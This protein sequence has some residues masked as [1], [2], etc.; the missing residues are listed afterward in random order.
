MSADYVARNMASS[1][2]SKNNKLKNRI[3]ELELLVKALAGVIIT[4][5]PEA[6]NTVAI[7]IQNYNET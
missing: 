5:I 4:H 1:V 6:N 7:M 3:I 2:N